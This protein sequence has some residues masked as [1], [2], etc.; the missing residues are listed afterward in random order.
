VNKRDAALN[1]VVDKLGKGV[2]KA[3]R[4]AEQGAKK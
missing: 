4:K 2:Q 3:I 1:T